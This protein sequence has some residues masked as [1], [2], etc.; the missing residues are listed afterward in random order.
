MSEIDFTR[1]GEAYREIIR[2]QKA[3]IERLKQEIRLLKSELEVR[4]AMR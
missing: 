2:E 1:P 4:K 3:E